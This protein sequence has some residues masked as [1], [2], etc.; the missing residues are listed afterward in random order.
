MDGI[1]PSEGPGPGSNPGRDTLQ[2]P[3]SVPDGTAV[4]E[5]A[6]RGSIPRWGAGVMKI[7]GVWRMAH[8]PAKVEGQVRLLTG[9]LS[10]DQ[11]SGIRDMKKRGASRTA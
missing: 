9:I 11:V 5:T 10:R 1:G 4:F 8:D 7:L 6:G 3:A 2:G